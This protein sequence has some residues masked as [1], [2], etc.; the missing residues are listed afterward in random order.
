[1]RIK[2]DKY[3]FTVFIVSMDNSKLYFDTLDGTWVADFQKKKDAKLVLQSIFET[4]FFDLNSIDN[5]YFVPNDP[6]EFGDDFDE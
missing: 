4:G 6:D 2:V 5:F 3:V 1:M